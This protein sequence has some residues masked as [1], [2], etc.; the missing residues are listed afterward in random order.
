MK[1]GRPLEAILEYRSAGAEAED[2]P[3]RQE[4]LEALFLA[5]EWDEA[6]T[7]ALALTVWIDFLEARPL[8]EAEFS[9]GMLAEIDR[10]FE[11][12]TDPA[13]EARLEALR[14]RFGVIAIEE[15]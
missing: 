8:A 12:G 10:R 6:A 5:E 9:R 7:L 1:S 4:L 2:S 14:G 15:G 11:N 3:L 13:D